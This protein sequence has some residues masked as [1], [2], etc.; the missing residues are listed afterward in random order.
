MNKKYVVFIVVLLFVV[1]CLV[2]IAADKMYELKEVK[3]AEVS[4]GIRE[5]VKE[6]QKRHDMIII[7]LR[8]RGPILPIKRGSKAWLENKI[9]W[10]L[11]NLVKGDGW[12]LTGWSKLQFDEDFNASRWKFG[13]I[14]PEMIGARIE[15]DV[16]PYHE[17]DWE[18]YQKSRDSIVVGIFWS[19]EF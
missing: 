9:D 4:E 10:T 18:K 6:K 2:S 1:P 16:D 8:K 12:Q 15:G 3:K 7:D 13:I 19:R 5:S 14:S 17:T 11:E